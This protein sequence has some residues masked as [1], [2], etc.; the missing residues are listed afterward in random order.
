MVAD[1]LGFKFLDV[2]EIFLLFA[3]GIQKISRLVP[4][5]VKSLTEA[6]PDNE[7]RP[8]HSVKNGTEDLA[9]TRE[10]E[11]KNEKQNG[12]YEKI[13]RTPAPHGGQISKKRKREK[14]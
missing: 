4:D 3:H 6:A 10:P 12:N 9:Q 5:G 1:Q 14:S 11:E 7:H 13:I 2:P 8:G